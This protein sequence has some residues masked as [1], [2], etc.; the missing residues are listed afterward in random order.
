MPFT[1][2]TPTLGSIAP[3][4]P[5]AQGGT[6][7]TT[8]AAGITALGGMSTLATTGLGGFALQ[9]A[10]PT[11][12]TWNV[13]N[14]GAMHQFWISES[15]VVT[16]AQT[17]GILTLAWTSP[18]GGARTVQVDAG[19]HGTGLANTSFTGRVCAPNTTVTLSQT[20]AQTAGTATAY[21]TIVGL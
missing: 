16:V 9:N 1:A 2:W 20:S 6:G 14:D 15:T 8:A 17:G 19:S 11:I 13:P 18:D 12:L 3:P 10:T 4:L 5:V 21:A 7:S